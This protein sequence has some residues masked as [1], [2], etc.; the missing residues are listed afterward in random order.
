MHIFRWL[1]HFATD[2]T[3]SVLCR[4]RESAQALVEFALVLLFVILPITFVLVDGALLLFV[5]VSVTN[6]AREGARAGSIYQCG[7]GGIECAF[8]PLQSFSAQV[9]TIDAA[10]RQY[11]DREAQSLIS[12]LIGY[13][14]CATTITYRCMSGS[15]CDATQPDMPGLGNPYREL[16]SMNVQIACPHQLLFGLVGTGVITVSAESTM[17]IEPG[18]VM[19]TPTPAP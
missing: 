4:E 11:I 18:G 17:R 10:R 12:S 13:S 9:T 7:S 16:D 15:L 8:D 3:R 5:Q 19:P 2:K 6:A 1:I 14:R